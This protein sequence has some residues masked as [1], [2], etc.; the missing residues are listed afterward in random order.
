MPQGGV[1]SRRGEELQMKIVRRQEQ[2][3]GGRLL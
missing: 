3:F 2:V 1:N